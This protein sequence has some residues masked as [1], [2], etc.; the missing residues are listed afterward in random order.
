VSV[1]TLGG[2]PNLLDVSWRAT[3]TRDY[4]VAGLAVLLKN[5]D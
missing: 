3:G 1:T 2:I 5:T 4:G